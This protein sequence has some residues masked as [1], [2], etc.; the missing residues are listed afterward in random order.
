MHKEYIEHIYGGRNKSIQWLI[1]EHN[2]LFADWFQQKVNDE[3]ENGE[4][5][6]QAIRWLAC[7]PS[8]TVLSFEGYL[9]DGVRYFTKDRDNARVVQNSGVSLVAKT[10]QVSSA[11][12]LNP[13]ESD[14][15]FYG[16]IEEIWEL[17]Y[18]A[19]KAPLF[20]CR[21]ADSDKGV[22]IDDLGFTLVDLSRQGHKN[23]KYVSVDQVKQI[24][25]VEDP[26]D[27]T[28]SVVL[29]STSRDYHEV[30]DDD[31]LGDTILENPPFCSKIPA[32]DPKANSG[33]LRENGEGIWIKK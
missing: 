21:W 24:F 17:D 9:V 22:K 28:W 10:V 12:D 19:F 7:K 18:H 3:I 2:R 13:V 1:G 25:Y 6:S 4:I 32:I 29:T 23:D 27:S 14:M 33:N 15:T 20:L 5:V 26:V 16:R 11:K 30:Y 31:E 8:F